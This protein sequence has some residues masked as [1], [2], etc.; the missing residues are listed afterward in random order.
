MM[1][2]YRQRMMTQT[3]SPTIVPPSIDP[4][5][6]PGGLPLDTGRQS[7]WDPMEIRAL[8]QS[9]RGVTYPAQRNELDTPAPL[10]MLGTQ[11]EAGR[12]YMAPGVLSA[13]YPK[14]QGSLSG[15]RAH[16]YSV[17][18]PAVPAWQVALKGMF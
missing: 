17:Q 2:E 11:E 16:D 8:I 10:G 15:A 9:L 3:G 7:P 12:Q 5:S 6:A 14:P 18:N 1:D 13:F 4:M